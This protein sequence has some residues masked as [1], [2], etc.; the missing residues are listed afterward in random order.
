[1]YPDNGITNL[2][3]VTEYDKELFNNPLNNDGSFLDI[4]AYFMTVTYNI[5]NLSTL[6]YDSNIFKKLKV[7]VTTEDRAYAHRLFVK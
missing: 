2:F 3:G 6:L 1:M 4:A 7:D 5:E